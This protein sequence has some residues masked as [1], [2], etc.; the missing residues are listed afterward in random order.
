MSDP[1]ISLAHVS[2]SYRHTTFEW[3][4]STWF[5]RTAAPSP[6]LRRVVIDD[7]SL[8]IHA[9]ES[10]ALIG[11]NGAGKSTLLKLI[12]GILVPD[13][14]VIAVRGRVSSLLELGIGFHPDLTGIE[15]IYFYGAMMGLK[16]HEITHLIP[17]IEAFADIGE[18]VR[19]PVKSY[20]SGMYQR[21]AFASAFAMHPDILIADEGLSVGDAMFQQK[22][23]NRI[24]DLSRQGT[25]VLVVAHSATAIM[26]IAR[27]GVWL[28]DGK[29]TMDGPVDKV[30]EA[31]A[32]AMVHADYAQQLSAVKSATALPV[33]PYVFMSDAICVRSVQI[34]DDTPAVW[35]VA[36]PLH[37]RAHIDVAVP[38]YAG[39]VRV[40][41][42]S[43]AENIPVLEN[44]FMHA[45]VYTLTQG[46]HVFQIT[47]PPHAI[48]A[49]LYRI[50]VAIFTED[51]SHREA[52]NSTLFVTAIN[53]HA[54]RDMAWFTTD[55][56]KIVAADA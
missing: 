23:L 16:R 3:P 18:Y 38:V 55:Q 29:I 45:N 17:E 44:D 49:G 40:R 56:M 21:L 9:G 8:T 35:D 20:S 15:N 30:A 22:C 43:A 2:K 7:V 12:S 24:E 4:W 47:I 32:S 51:G 1:V 53:E 37:V 26:R 52:A 5:A 13:A 46:A 39:R 27:R 19:Q 36:Q 42:I 28:Q 14:G 48:K 25:T 6:A 10:V 33:N 50:G 31:Y 41:V 34:A 54:I 11:N